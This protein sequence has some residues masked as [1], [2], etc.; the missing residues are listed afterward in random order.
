MAGGGG[1]MVDINHIADDAAV[2][3]GTEA[4]RKSYLPGVNN[5]TREMMRR[6]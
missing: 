6:N 3:G 4:F 5:D 2:V 1:G